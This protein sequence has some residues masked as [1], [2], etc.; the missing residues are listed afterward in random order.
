MTDEM[1]DRHIL[2]G[3][4]PEAEGQASDGVI[5]RRGGREGREEGGGGREKGGEERGEGGGKGRGGEG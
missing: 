3:A 4:G 1:I 2:R 5:M